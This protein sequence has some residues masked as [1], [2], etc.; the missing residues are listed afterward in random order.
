MTSIDL[1]DG[2]TKRC[3]YALEIL[4]VNKKS[5]INNNIGCHLIRISRPMICKFI[6]AVNF[7]YH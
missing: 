5:N 7:H 2:G 6:C 4:Y 1:E 3:C